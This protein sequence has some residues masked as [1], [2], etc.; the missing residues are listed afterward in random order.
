MTMTNISTYV[1]MI[2]REWSLRFITWM[3]NDHDIYLEEETFD[4]LMEACSC[5]LFW[6][7]KKLNDLSY[8]YKIQQDVIQGYSLDGIDTDS[9]FKQ[10][11]EHIPALF[12]PLT[13][14]RQNNTIRSIEPF[15]EH[16]ILKGFIIHVI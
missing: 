4:Y 10:W 2:E 3:T 12:N 7:M 15:M 9:L 14:I 1:I 6:I 13:I 8:Q 5:Y 16:Y 11:D